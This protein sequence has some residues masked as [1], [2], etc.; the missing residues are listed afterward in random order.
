M[1]SPLPSRRVTRDDVAKRA[2]VSSATVSYVVNN[3]PRQVSPKT[4]AKV[5]AAI[6]ELGYRP[7]AVARNL[8]MQRT[9]TLGLIIPDTF[10]P[11]FA[12]VARG[13]ESVAFEN[14]YIVV[15]CHSNYDIEKELRYVDVLSSER[16]AGVIWVPATNQL[17]PADRLAENHIPFLLLDR[18]TGRDSVLSVVADNFQGGYLAT[19]HL[20][21]LGHKRIGCITRP[22]PLDHSNDRIRGYKTALEDHGLPID[23]QLLVLGGYRFED[24]RRAARELLTSEAPPTAIVGYNDLMA[25]GALRAAG[26][27]GL[28][29]PEDL[30]IVGFDDIPGA[31][32]TFPPLTSVC[33]PKEEMGRRAAELLLNAIAGENETEQSSLTIEVSLNQRQST[34]PPKRR[35]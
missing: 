18:N 27:L 2:G 19:E 9:S 31:A 21:S 3:G 1:K 16:A 14:G 23:Q 15:L 30:S 22:A 26:E 13:I 5:L 20:I 10:N 4:Q 33:L 32:F 28:K 29:V 17:E 7:N 34:A 8:R 6:E 35:Q 11:Y 25:I 24:G 12:E